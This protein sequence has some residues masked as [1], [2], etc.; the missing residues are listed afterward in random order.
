MIKAPLQKKPAA[1]KTRKPAASK[2]SEPVP[3]PDEPE[4]PK[5]PEMS[6]HDKMMWERV[7]EATTE[8]D[9]AHPEAP[10]SSMSSF[11]QNMF[12]QL[13]VD[14]LSVQMAPDAS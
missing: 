12:A 9:L 6:E 14:R 3:A 4:P 13:V 2:T 8:Y 1:R 5:S 10:V 11:D 7:Q